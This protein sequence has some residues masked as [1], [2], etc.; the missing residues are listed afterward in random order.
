M[1]R[2]IVVR[3]SY[4][5]VLLD[6]LSQLPSSSSSI[7]EGRK[8]NRLASEAGETQDRVQLDRVRCHPGLTVVEVE[9]GD[10]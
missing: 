6:T 4:R 2:S 3:D 9:E 8:V 10:P 5:I 1:V 7:D